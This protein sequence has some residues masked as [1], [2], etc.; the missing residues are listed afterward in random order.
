MIGIAIND[1]PV[2]DV[3][4]PTLI[5]SGNLM[6]MLLKVPDSLIKARA[7][8]NDVPEPPGGLLFNGARAC[9]CNGSVVEPD[10]NRLAYRR[11]SVLRLKPK[12]RLP[13]NLFVASNNSE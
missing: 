4:I 12:H 1:R 5:L 8:S 10:K 2:Y 3:D 11:A 13:S 7:R 9:E 6:L